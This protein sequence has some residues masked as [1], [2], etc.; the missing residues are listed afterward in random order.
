MSYVNLPPETTFAK[1]DGIIR[2]QRRLM[3]A[4]VAVSTVIMATSL[5]A[6]LSMI[7]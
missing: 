7:F 4:N 6:S 1:L 5:L 3:V 2:S